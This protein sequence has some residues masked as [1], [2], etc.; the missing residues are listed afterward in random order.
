MGEIVTGDVRSAAS[1]IE[2][3]ASTVRSHV[4]SEVGGV[5]AALSG[6]AS[7]GAGSALATAWGEAYEAW[8]TRAEE[9]GTRM[10]DA[11]SDWE[12]TNQGVAQRF[13]APQQVR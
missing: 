12:T 5:A 2:L 11:A 9:Q 13:T 4:P 1:Y 8:A 3:V 6:S 10:R 7:G